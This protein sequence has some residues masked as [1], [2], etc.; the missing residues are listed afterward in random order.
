MIYLKRLL[1]LIGAIPVYLIVLFFIV[2]QGLFIPFLVFFYFLKDGEIDSWMDSDYN[3][4]IVSAFLCDKYDE[5][6]DFLNKKIK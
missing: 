4:I 2:L 5:L 6:L 3:P 1:W